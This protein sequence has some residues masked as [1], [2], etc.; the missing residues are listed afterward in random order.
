MRRVALCLVAALLAATVV[1]A[2]RPVDIP[3]VTWQQGSKSQVPS[4]WRD[5][6]VADTACIDCELNSGSCIQDATIFPC[7]ADNTNT[8]GH[9]DFD[10]GQLPSDYWGCHTRVGDNV[11]FA[12]EMWLPKKGPQWHTWH[13][14]LTQKG[15]RVP[16]NAIRFHDSVMAKSMYNGAG[17]CIGRGYTG[18]AVGKD[19]GTFGDVYFTTGGSESNANEFQVAIC[20]AY[21]PTPAPTPAPTAGPTPPPTPAPTHAP[22]TLP[23]SD[24]PYIRFGNAI[25]AA[26]R[27]K[28]VISQGNVSKTWTNMAFAEFSSWT[29]IFSS[30][31]GTIKIYDAATNEL[32]LTKEIPLTPGPLVV[33]T[34]GSW[35]PVH[36]LTSVET[37]AASYIPV[38]IPD[39][40]GVRLFNLAD[41]VP[42]AGLSVSGNTILNDVRYTIGS[43][44]APVQVEQLDFAIFD[45]SNN[46]T[47]AKFST[48]PPQPPYVFT[49][50]LLGLANATGAYATR[51]VPLIDAPEA[52]YQYHKV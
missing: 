4:D 15:A 17:T 20:K 51:A 9:R 10:E 47:L 35:P 12:N 48:T 8:W 38:P 29:E 14:Q 46:K 22:P 28:A 39:T 27:V 32:Q 33:V 49:A 24:R 31:T 16:D 44:W 13:W 5:L 30:G 52:F 34:K 1:V 23:P 41:D 2:D 26:P 18:W 45:D 21:H 42:E 25:A 40:S 6:F 36:S 11:V 3:C 19:D 43:G 37:I 50:F 7:F